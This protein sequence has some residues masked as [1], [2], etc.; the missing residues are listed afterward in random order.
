M[1]VVVIG[2][3]GVAAFLFVLKKKNVQKG[4]LLSFSSPFVVV[5]AAAVTAVAAVQV[6]CV[7]GVWS[8]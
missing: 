8:A 3:V 7:F 5:V 6:L 2:V 4:V 1:V